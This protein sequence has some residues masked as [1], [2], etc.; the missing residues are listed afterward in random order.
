MAFPDLLVRLSRPKPTIHPDR[1][2]SDPL[3]KP[4][5]TAPCPSGPA[6]VE[7]PSR[8]LAPEQC[9]DLCPSALGPG[10]NA[11]PGGS[12]G[13]GDDLICLAPLRPARGPRPSP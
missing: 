6:E 5:E 12:F 4:L 8:S 3:L 7:A 10:P 9:L 11:V 1:W 2:S 13:V